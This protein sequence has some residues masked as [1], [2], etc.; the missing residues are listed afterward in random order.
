M[1]ETNDEFNIWSPLALVRVEDNIF[2]PRLMFYNLL[3]Y[4][5]N[6]QIE[7][8]WSFGTQENIGMGVIQNL[9]ISTPPIETQK[10]IVEYLD[11]EVGKINNY[12]K[13]IN[14]RI[15]LFKEYRKSLIYN[16]VT[17]KIKV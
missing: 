17:G 16:A 1:V 3:S 13:Q 7:I 15:R 6:K 2:I 9:L 5:F 4:Y 10:R 12:T 14:N 8:S 11:S